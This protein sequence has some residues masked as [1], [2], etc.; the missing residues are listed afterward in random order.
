MYGRWSSAPVQPLQKSC[1]LATCC[2]LATELFCCLR[3]TPVKELLSCHL[4]GMPSASSS[5]P[6]PRATSTLRP[7]RA[8][9]GYQ[10]LRVCTGAGHVPRE[11]FSTH[12][13]WFPPRATST[14]P[15]HVRGKLKI[16]RF[17]VQ[18]GVHIGDLKQ[19]SNRPLVQMGI[20]E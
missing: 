5:R 18:I 4:T 6:L 12:L 9:A 1:C 15:A 20:F 14:H 10:T 17:A 13:E 11:Q 8:P 3:T 7:E 2:Y 16:R 19:T